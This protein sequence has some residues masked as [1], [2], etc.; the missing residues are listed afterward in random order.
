MKSKKIVTLILL[1][2]M[3]VGTLTM[4]GCGKQSSGDAKQEESSNS[5]MV[6]LYDTDG[7]TVLDTIT[8][9][10]GQ[11]ADIKD[12]K[13]DG[14][15]FMGWYQT[16]KLSRKADLNQPI[17]ENTDLYAGFAEYK[18]DTREF[19]IV[20]S[21]ESPVLTESN[22]G[23]VTGDQQKMTKQDNKEANVYT[24]TVDL[25]AG[26]QFQFA[27]DGNWSDQR[28]Y[29]YLASTK[30]DGKEYFK[31]AGSLGD[32]S[33]KKANIEVSESGK[34]TFTLT[35]YP[36]ADTYDTKDSYY[37]EEKKENF[38]INPYDT[39]TFTYDGQ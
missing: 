5:V 8:V 23:A 26:D 4:T 13:K 17:E 7:E 10:K 38:N 22:W 9:D 18:E 14:F 20:G 36:A 39:I 37:S 19:Y 2:T 15:T 16:P 32:A 24:I 21:G 34:Y 3:A 33:V 25:K 12:P 30:Q 11:K 1:T 27:I 6:T 29:G 35:T 31:N 28:G